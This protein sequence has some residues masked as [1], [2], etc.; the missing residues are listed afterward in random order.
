MGGV[1]DRWLVNMPSPPTVQAFGGNRKCNVSVL[2]CL[3]QS[4]CPME[5]TL[6]F[7]FTPVKCVHFPIHA[8]PPQTMPTSRGVGGVCTCRRTFPI[9][10]SHCTPL[11]IQSSISR[12]NPNPSTLTSWVRWLLL[13]LFNLLPSIWWVWF[14][15]G[16]AEPSGRWFS[17]A[18][19]RSFS[20]FPDGIM[21]WCS[22]M[23]FARRIK[24]DREIVNLTCF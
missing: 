2:L 9:L 4:I 10:P 11:I 6:L 3:F 14:D 1:A 20:W 8:S 13:L 23:L 15:F 5:F 12:T 21:G 7:S 24:S 17:A 19:A 18:G 16:G 22:C